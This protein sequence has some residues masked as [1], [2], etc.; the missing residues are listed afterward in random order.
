MPFCQNSGSP[1]TIQ[2]RTVVERI[3]VFQKETLARS[4][5]NMYGPVGIVSPVEILG[6]ILLKVRFRPSACAFP[7]SVKEL[8]PR[9]ACGKCFVKEAIL[10]LAKRLVSFVL[11]P[12]WGR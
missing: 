5:P 6:C 1:E 4:L 2:E 10:L 12:L 11:G 3:N 8:L 9:C 7:A